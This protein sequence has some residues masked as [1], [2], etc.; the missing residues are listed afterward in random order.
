MI[1]AVNDA[2]AMT[3]TG[4]R[5][6]AQAQQIAS[7]MHPFALPPL[8]YPDNSLEPVISARTLK[9]H[10]GVHH[11][12]YVDKVNELVAGTSFAQQSL[13]QILLATAAQPE[14]TALF[15][16][17]AQAWNHAFYWHSLRPR[18]GGLPA[19]ALEAQIA[20][21]FGGVGALKEAL[22]GAAKSLFGSGWVWLVSDGARLRVVSTH[23]AD[24]P[25]VDQ[26]TPL[27]VI[28]VWEHAYY[29]DVQNRRPEYVQGILE[30]FINWEF[31]AANARGVHA[32]ELA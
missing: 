7:A 28:D 32:D 30:N 6:N 31:A 27:L 18:G 11:Q 10:H 22:A 4:D 14:H 12:V 9:L 21:S 25:L 13:R 3:G 24:N 20:A 15:E 16:N 17:A 29:L 19:P 5:M 26:Y 1:A 2:A 23:N 8:P